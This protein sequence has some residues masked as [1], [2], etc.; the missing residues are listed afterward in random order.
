MLAPGIPCAAF[1]GRSGSGDLDSQVSTTR[2]GEHNSFV[3]LFSGELPSAERENVA[4][5]WPFSFTGFF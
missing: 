1:I 3:S 4:D 2:R 5:Y